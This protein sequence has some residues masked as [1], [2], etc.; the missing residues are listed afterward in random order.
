MERRRGDGVALEEENR[1]KGIEGTMKRK[2]LGVG[3]HG[4]ER[5]ER[6]VMVIGDCFKL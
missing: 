3:D 4:R 5:G 2:V 6:V 1:E